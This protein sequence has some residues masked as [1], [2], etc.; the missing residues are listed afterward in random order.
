MRN[1][2]KIF[3]RDIKKVVTNWVAIVVL[4]GL[5][6]LPSLYAWFNIKSSWD[7]YGSTKGIKIAVVN[8]DKGADFGGKDLNVG[9]KVT[10]E[11]SKND[12]I[13]WQ[14]VNKEKAD[15][16]IRMGE[17]FA[18]IIIPE[19]FSKDL[20]SP[21]SNKIVKPKLIYT[22]NE[23][24]NAI[25]PKITDKGVNTLKENVD[26]TVSETVNGIIFKVLNNVGIEYKSSRDKIREVVDLIY[27]VNDNM[28]EIE[29]L[30]NKAYDGTITIDQMLTK[31][32]KIIP[33]LE[34]TLKDA[35][36]ALNKGKTFLDKS[37]ESFNSLSPII[38]EDLIF[39][40]D[41]LNGSSEILGNVSQKYDKET[42]LK[43]LNNANNKLT[44]VNKTLSS[45][46]DILESIN[47]ISN[48]DLIGN[49][50]TRLKAIESK[51]SSVIEE[52]N[53]DIS[54]VNNNK[55]LQPE[56]IVKLKN[57]VDSISSNLGE[58]ISKYDSNIVPAINGSL[59]K[60]DDMSKNAIS[61]ID[62][63]QNV[64]PDVKNVLSLLSK[65]T[66]LTNEQLIKV[67]KDFPEFKKSF[68]KMANQIK[69]IDN[70]SGIDEILKIITGDWKKQ[71]D[72]L[73]SPVQIET[74]R[75]FPVP[76]YGSAMS[77]FYTTLALWVGGLILVSILTVKVKPFEDGEVPKPIEV[78]FGKYLTFV[79]IGILQGAVV[80]L[81][82]IFILKTYVIHPVLFVLFGMFASL[83][84]ITIIYSTVSVFGNVGKAICIIFL[85]LQVAASGGTFPVEVMSNFF[86][87]INP[88]LPFKYAIQGMRGL[89][90]GVV[91]ELMQRDIIIL[92]IV[93][94]IF[95]II[96]IFLKKPINKTSEKFVNKLKESDI[97]EH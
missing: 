54:L 61:L 80:T 3:K 57:K 19:D 74:N 52:I 49:T 78:F 20:I 72:F 66:K 77:P 27:K 69:K 17:Y 90:G 86:K 76:N 85:V 93:A 89:V 51:I 70:K 56:S 31:I 37:K 36:G 24:S 96:G 12:K 8:E 26:N 22:V 29:N 43:V 95:M 55:V 60:L 44:T 53:K 47:K 32:D 11:L 1:I 58:I 91:P 39:G 7:P 59:T 28:P 68:N 65:G 4:L 63:T 21:A 48:K 82:D 62:S 10:E 25:A 64:M 38:K 2:L 23:S 83:I 71:T 18:S 75:L 73:V 79:T 45:V 9:N 41:L 81:G 14:F 50:L 94:L 30:I 16:G 67:K 84:F 13:G 92:I 42:L 6:I 88:V 40:R 33:N 15:N 97:V 5:I 46:I 34:S 87:E 35:N